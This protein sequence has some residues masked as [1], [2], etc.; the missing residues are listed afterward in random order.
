[1]RWLGVLSGGFVP[2]MA[3][4]AFFA[5]SA[6]RTHWAE[7]AIRPTVHALAATAVILYGLLAVDGTARRWF[8]RLVLLRVVQVIGLAS[9]SIY[10]VHHVLDHW[11]EGFVDGWP[12][13]V[14]AA[15]LIVAGTAGGVALY[16]LVE[17]P[18]LSARRALDGRRGRER[19]AA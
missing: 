9:Y 2:V 8:H 4:S 11:L 12:W 19:V 3:V 18:A 14:R 1:M 7:L 6:I 15:V 5:A 10:L 13:P 17:R 16:F